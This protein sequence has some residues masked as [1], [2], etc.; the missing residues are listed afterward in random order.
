MRICDPRSH[1][2]VDATFFDRGTTLR[3]YHRRSDSHI[4]TLKATALVDTDSCA[5][6]DIHC[7][8]H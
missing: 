8:A 6:L 2:A 1:G 3:H 5:I 7:S 4:R